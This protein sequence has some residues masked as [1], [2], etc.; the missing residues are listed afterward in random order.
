[1][2]LTAKQKANLDKLANYLE[3]LPKRYRHFDMHSYHEAHDPSAT[4][5]QYAD[6]AMNNGGVTK[7]ACGAVACAIG[8]GPA[9]GILMTKRL[10]NPGDYYRPQWGTYSFQNFAPSGNHWDWMFS[11][12]WTRIDNGHRGAAARIRYVLAGRSLPADF[13]D[14]PKLKHRAFYQEFR[15]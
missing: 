2:T 10:A 1:M 3:G 15:V 12:E 7:H 11:S 4:L 14:T 9:A 8:H 13:R 6:Y 5:E